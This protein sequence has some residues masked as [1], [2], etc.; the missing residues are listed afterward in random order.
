MGFVT[1]I[2]LKRIV[3]A[4]YSSGHVTHESTPIGHG[5]ADE[6]GAVSC[7]DEKVDNDCSL[8]AYVCS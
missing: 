1:Q 6:R 3:L 2:E 7:G 8:L 5:R 4:V